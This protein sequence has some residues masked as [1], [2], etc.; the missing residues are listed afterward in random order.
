MSKKFFVLFSIFF[1]LFV[2]AISW[3]TD[4]PLKKA[5]L[6]PQWVPHAQFAG[7]YMALEKGF[8][9]KYGI[10]LTIIPGGPANSPS[11]FLMNGKAQFATMWLATGIQIRADGS[12]IINLAQLFKRSALMLVAKKSSGINTPRGIDGK[13]V[14]V[15][16]PV[17]QIQ[18]RAFFKRYGLKVKLIPQSYSV[19]LFLRD[20]VD[21]ASAM[22]YNEYH[23]ILNSGLNPEELT[24]FFF[25]EHGLNFPED[26]IYTTE[27][28]F[29]KDPGLCSSFKNASLEG[30]NYAFSHRE[31]ALDIVMRNL[32]SEHIPATRVHQRWMLERTKDL[33]IPEGKQ[34]TMGRLNREDYFRVANALKQ[35]GF[36]KRIPDFKSFCGR[37]TGDDEK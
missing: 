4:R 9:K 24:T 34:S 25:H 26:G 14:G 32:K 5:T 17:F 10:D 30:W 21:V 15:W 2:T 36:I 16:G 7:Y 37:R 28:I 20:G 11:D 27:E 23:T 6:I 3:A 12:G 35:N 1:F 8:Y 29:H 31:E 13:K 18:P 22:W 33:I 19:N